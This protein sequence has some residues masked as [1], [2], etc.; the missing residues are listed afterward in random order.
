[1]TCAH[2]VGA[3]PL[4]M[5]SSLESFPLETAGWREATSYHCVV[6]P[7]NKIISYLSISK[8]KIVFFFKGLRLALLFSPSPVFANA[9]M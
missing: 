3:Q 8:K 9:G 4:L 6:N 7:A 2:W 5:G 1:M